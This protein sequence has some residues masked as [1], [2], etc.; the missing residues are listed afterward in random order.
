MW[1]SIQSVWNLIKQWFA[2]LVRF[3]SKYATDVGALAAASPRSVTGSP[4]R[5]WPP[6]RGR[7][8]SS[9]S[10]CPHSRITLFQTRFSFLESGR[11]FL[12]RSEFLEPLR[13]NEKL[14]RK[15]SAQNTQ[16]TLSNLFLHVKKSFPLSLSL[17]LSHTHTLT[18]SF[19][20]SRTHTLTL[21]LIIT[22][23]LF[24]LSLQLTHTP[25]FFPNFTP[26][27]FSPSPS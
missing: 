9:P 7:N 5:E 11:N 21:S 18:H 8:I 17:S 19:P 1:I 10:C 4:E 13:E 14:R 23:T 6:S 20:H 15:P 26:S 3:Q 12:G 24:L 22:H 27:C 16:H 25:S 2:Q